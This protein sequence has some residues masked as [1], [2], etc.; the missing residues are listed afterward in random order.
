[1]RAMIAVLAVF[2]SLAAQTPTNAA[3]RSP[4]SSAGVPTPAL[5][6]QG[7]QLLSVSCP[8]AGECL[9]VGY[10][11]PSSRDAHPEAA[12]WNGKKWTLMPTPA[13]P[14]TDGGYLAGISCVSARSCVAVGG[15]NTDAV[16]AE[17]WNGR[18]WKLG[19]PVQPPG[20]PNA[21]SNYGAGFSSV[22]C[23]PSG[24]CVAVGE[25][26]DTPSGLTTPL[27][28]V[29]RD[30]R[31]S[32]QTVP[33]G[34]VR[35]HEQL[36]SVSCASPRLCVAVGS[37]Q[38]Y[39]LRDTWN[40]RNW[41]ALQFTNVGRVESTNPSGVSCFSTTACMIIGYGQLE[42]VNYSAPRSFAQRWDGKR[43]ENRTFPNRSDFD[44]LAIACPATRRC[45]AVGNTSSTLRSAAIWR[46]ERWTQEPVPF[47]GGDLYSSLNGVSCWTA[48]R[49][50]AVGF[51]YPP[52]SMTSVNLAALYRPSDR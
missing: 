32:L 49:C 41:S 37:G 34:P 45:V 22:S 1:M 20:V 14:G 46:G 15:T 43:W 17:W 29:M 24:R 7:S 31:W 51:F 5:A 8:T 48:I 47:S 36:Q 44:G 38:P 3:H 13:I 11:S 23:L 9:A 40:G 16:L 21:E 10:F 26:Q 27:A 35:D 28:E 42:S 12:R 4:W 2:A 52:N 18:R 6:T 33:T 25:A 50:M 19:S 39:R 30:H